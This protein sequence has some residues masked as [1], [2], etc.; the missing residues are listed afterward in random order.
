MGFNSAFKG[1]SFINGCAKSG[2]SNVEIAARP[3]ARK[4]SFYGF[5]LYF[6]AVRLIYTLNSTADGD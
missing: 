2:T 6:C 1:L 4:T 3:I 5:S